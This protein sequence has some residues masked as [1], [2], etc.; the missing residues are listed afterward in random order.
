MSAFASV[1]I[2]HQNPASQVL[3]SFMICTQVQM[4]LDFPLSNNIFFFVQLTNYIIF[5]YEF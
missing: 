3:L 2:C 1:F 4:D 5:N